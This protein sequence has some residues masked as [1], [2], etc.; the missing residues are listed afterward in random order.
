MFLQLSGVGKSTLVN[1]L[2][3]A[4]RATGGVNDVTGARTSHLFL[5]QS[6]HGPERV[7]E[8]GSWTPRHPLLGLAHVSEENLLRVHD[9]RAATA[10]PGAAGTREDSPGCALDAWPRRPEALPPRWSG[11]SRCAGCWRRC[12]GRPSR[13]TATACRGDTVGACAHRA[14]TR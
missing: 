1:A 8:R 5:R 3:G 6:P 14:T 11:W 10:P 7:R 12:V 13:A 2:T 9:P 4:E